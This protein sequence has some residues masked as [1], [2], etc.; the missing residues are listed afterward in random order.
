MTKEANATVAK[1]AEEPSSVFLLN[2]LDG[3]IGLQLPGMREQISG[4]TRPGKILALP[5]GWSLQPP[6][7]WEQAKKNPVTQLMLRDRIQ[8][9]AAP[10]QNQ[11]RVGH[12]KIEEGPVVPSAAPL[13]DVGQD[14]ALEMIR[15]IHVVAMLKLLLREEKREMVAKELRVRLERIEKAGR[16]KATGL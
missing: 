2:N 6:D 8:P 14:Q 7:L 5:P 1:P 15:E 4:T 16:G 11:A 3:P 10:E 12:P 13:R 9:S